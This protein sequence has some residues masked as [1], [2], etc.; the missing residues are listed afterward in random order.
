MN[1]DKYKHIMDVYNMCKC[2]QT[3]SHAEEKPQEEQK[4]AEDKK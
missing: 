3:V 1:S 2:E 4:P